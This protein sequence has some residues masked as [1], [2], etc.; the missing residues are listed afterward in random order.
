MS[1]TPKLTREQVL[2][3]SSLLETKT[4]REISEGFGV[5]Q[6]AIFYWIGKLRKKGVHVREFKRG[7]KSLL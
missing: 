3:I 5:S 6:Q 1:N 2:S 7:R 4:P